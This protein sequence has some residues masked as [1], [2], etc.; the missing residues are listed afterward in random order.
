MDWTSTHLPYRQT[1][2]FSRIITDYL[3]QAAAIN[4]FYSYPAT[5]EGL[6]KAIEARKQSPVDRAVLVE[7]LKNQYAG[8]Q[9]APLVDANIEKLKAETTFTIVTAHQPA[10]FTGHLYFIYKILHTIRL[11]SHLSHRYPAC[12]FVPVFY[13]GSED[14]DLDELGNVYLG[15]D[16]LVWDTKQTGAVGRMKTKGLDKL[17]FR[18]EGELSVQPFGKELMAMLREAY[19]ESPDIQ[20]ATFRLLHRLFAEWGLIVLIADLPAFKRLMIPIFEDDLFRNKPSE[21]VNK[22]IEQLSVHYK[23][24]AN[25][26]AI[27]L[28]YL[29][30]DIRGRI[31]QDGEDYLVHT[32][33]LRFTKDQLT[34]EL[35][36]NPERFSPNVILRGLFQERILPNIAFIGGGGETAYWLEL[37]ALFGHY[38]TPFPVLVLRN[39]FLL[40]EQQ[41]KEKAERMGFGLADLFKPTEELMNLLVKRD[42]QQTLD[43]GEEIAVANRYYESLKELAR[44]VDPTL[45][46]HVMALQTKA[47][48]PLRVLEK[49]LLRAEKRKFS[50]QQRQLQA[51]KATLFPGDGLQERMDNFMPWYA[52]YG[53]EFI[54]RL[55]DRSPAL[56]QQFVLLSL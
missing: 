28:F 24:Q 22:T 56:E 43:L 51:L 17:L 46:Q 8:V 3:D 9:P 12:H 18:I 38:Q 39:S 37:K 34:E 16:K 1:G 52:T 5:E 10:I 6:G 44:P 48:E 40:V 26:R 50:D 42:S 23:V 47:V 15:G 49:K 54:Q 29:K 35:H 2:Y 27:N 55:Y 30:D 53:K 4:P 45:E 41:W 19:L 14:A 7:A 36:R 13:M 20:T 31:E 33:D 25:P 32:T 11:A 21:I